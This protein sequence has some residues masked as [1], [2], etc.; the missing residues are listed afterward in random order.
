MGLVIAV[1]LAV[2]AGIVVIAASQAAASSG[3]HSLTLPQTG[4]VHEGMSHDQAATREDCGDN[5]SGDHGSGGTDCCGMGACHAVQLTAA[6][7]LHSPYVSAA[8]I[9]AIG[10]EQV[11][12]IT[13][14]G[15]D[16]PPR[17]I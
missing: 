5:S 4:H 15:L 2:T 17:T 11:D 14:G 7:V 16:R 12:G 8:A 3:R 10:N 1:L 9:A 13:A 6:P